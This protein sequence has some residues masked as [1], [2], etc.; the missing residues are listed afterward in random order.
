MK[1]LLSLNQY[2]GSGIFGS[3][4]LK[5]I[6]QHSVKLMSYYQNH[7]I[8][9]KIDW[10]IDPIISGNDNYFSEHFSL[11]RSPKTNA[12]LTDWILDDVALFNPDLIISYAEPIA[13][14]IGQVLNIKVWYCSP[15]FLAN[16]C[17]NAFRGITNQKENLPKADRYF[18]Y[19]PSFVEPS[20]RLP[21]YEIVE[22][23]VHD[24]GEYVNEKL[25]SIFKQ[26]IYPGNSII[27]TGEMSYACDLLNKDRR[28]ILTPNFNNKEQVATSYVFDY[29]KYGKN[30]YRPESFSL[31]NNSLRTLYDFKTYK[32]MRKYLHEA[33]NGT[34]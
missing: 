34:N 30:I 26:V 8:F 13:A 28:I 18:V 32:P 1:I 16:I 19:A 17:P 15:T 10:V 7:Q 3:R 20:K 14:L 4:F 33:L 21:E 2:T 23:Y 12:R 25:P 22:P 29:Y 27:T 24:C 6:R 9:S 11:K 31:L 5:H